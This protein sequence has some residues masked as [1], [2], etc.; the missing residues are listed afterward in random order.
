MKR[1]IEPNTNLIFSLRDIGY[2][3]ETAIADVIDNSISAEAKNIEIYAPPTTPLMISII[4]DGKGLN[5]DEL[6]E[7][8]TLA[9]IS[10][11]ESRDKNDLGR[12]G[13]GLKTATWSQ[14]K[15][16]TI[17][18]SVDGKRCAATIDLDEI[19]E[20]NK[21]EAQFHSEE[22]I[23]QIP[24]ADKVKENGT[25]V[26]WEKLDRVEQSTDKASKSAL[27]EKITDAR[28][29]LELVFHRFLTHEV[30]F[31]T[32]RISINGLDLKGFDPFAS[33]EPSTQMTPDEVLS[34]GDA[35]DVVIRAYTLPHHSKLTK[36]KETYYA[37]TKGYLQSQGFYLYR[38]RRLIV[39]GSWFR[40]A[41]QHP[42]WNLSRIRIDIPN[43]MDELWSINIMKAHAQPPQE[44]K[45]R[46]RGLLDELGAPSQR[47]YRK[48]GYDQ[49]QDEHFPVWIKTKAQ[50]EISYSLDIKHPIITRFYDDL[51][52]EQR[53]RFSTVLK[54][55]SSTLPLDTLFQ[56]LG[57]SAENVSPSK[58]DEAAFLEILDAAYSGLSAEF[59]VNQI[60]DILYRKEPFRSNLEA[61][62][63]FLKERGLD[64]SK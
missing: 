2:S 18:S 30:G 38:Q 43:T 22:S 29:H 35:G 45:K 3:F 61:L 26:L 52:T 50:G 19:S 49:I 10:S 11:A 32:V 12:F 20:S 36:E 34:L 44:V 60:Y 46:L 25:L 6:V 39:W 33:K 24:T 4:D 41:K 8:L 56:D 9:F 7:A 59:N 21:W 31:P 15:R 54:L 5:E 48:R 42:S 62:K 63:I 14:C 37:H 57:V 1:S 64:E 51:N 28:N 16:L 23:D 53:T 58:V 27:T 47:I 40:L 55:I 17:V 13:M